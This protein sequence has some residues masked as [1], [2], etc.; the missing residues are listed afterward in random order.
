MSQQIHN[1]E[2]VYDEH[3]RILIL[4]SFPSVRSRETQFFYGHPQN[5]FWK[6][7]ARIY[8]EDVPQ[9]VEQKKA[10]LRK[11]NI[12]IWDVIASCDINGSSDSSIRNVVPNDISII[13]QTCHICHIYCNG[14]QSYRLYRKYVEPQLNR[15]AVCLPSTS[16][17]NAAWDLNKLE[18]SWNIIRRSVSDDSDYGLSQGTYQMQGK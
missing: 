13:T 3:S 16:P 7:L 17:A 12:A 2:P 9:N 14:K 6:L 5:R 8:E 15:E 18:S 4:G 11:N 10:F 1:I